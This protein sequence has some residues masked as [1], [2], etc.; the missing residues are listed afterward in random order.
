LGNL[1][2]HMKNKIGPLSC[3]TLNNLIKIFKNLNIILDTLILQ[4]GII[5]ENLCDIVQGKDFFGGDILSNY[6]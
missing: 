3:Y 5:W 1:D 6:E 4:K 2:T